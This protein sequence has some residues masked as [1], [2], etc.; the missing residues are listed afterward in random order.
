MSDDK[1]PSTLVADLGGTNVRFGLA[2]TTQARPLIDASIRHYAVADF[3]SLADAARHYLAEIGSKPQRG[4]FA[5]AGKVT[6]DEV[7]ITNHPWVISIAQTRRDLALLSLHIVNDFAGLSMA[8]PLL[9]AA[10]VEKIGSAEIAVAA[11]TRCRTIGVIGPGT[12]LGVGAFLLRD[13]KPEILETE[14]GHVGFAPG[15][16]EEIAILQYL[17]KR[18]G[19]VSN[20]RLICGSGMVNVYQALCALAGVPAQNFSPAQVTEHA[21]AGNDAQCVRTVD[22]FCALLGSIAGDLVL[23]IGAWDGIYLAGGIVPPLL[24][25]LRKAEFRRR[26]DEKG[27]FASAMQRVPTLAITYPYAGLLGAA[28]TAVVDGGGHLIALAQS[29]SAVA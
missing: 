8:V 20:E 1:N 26:F 15:T 21:Q 17:A 14:G 4:V 29:K 28:A 9:A 16:P 13:G 24:P 7:R 11:N 19:R 12:G 6:A 2:Q 5:V 22:I 25:W 18:Y 27:R 23:T 3:A 10:D